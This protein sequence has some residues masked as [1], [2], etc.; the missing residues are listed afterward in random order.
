MADP[1]NVL[2]CAAAMAVVWTAIGW[3][4]ASRLETGPAAWCWAP[5]LGLALHSVVALPLLGW[6]GMDRPAVIAVTIALGAIA[7]VAGRFRHDRPLLAPL[8]IAKPLS[9]AM[10]V[11]VAAA[12]LLA[13]VPAAAVLPKTTDQGVTLAA[14]I[15]DHSKIAMIDEMIR[16][17]VPPHNPFIGPL[18][19]EAGSPDR[20]AYYYLWHFSAA[21]LA[22]VTGATGWEADAALTW[23][24]AF[25]SLLTMIGLAVRLGGKA[26]APAIVVV[27]AATASIRALFEWV[28]PDFTTPYLI[29][30]SGL[31]GWLF[32]MAWAPQHMA[33]ATCVVL[34]CLLLVRTAGR[35]DW[36][37]PPVLALVAAAGY[38][39]SIWVGGVTF[40][41][42]AVAIALYLLWSLDAPRRPGFLLRLLAAAILAL[43]F[44]LPFL[45]DQLAAGAARGGGA[46]VAI[47]PVAVLGPAFPASWRALLDL[48]AYWLVYL[49]V[50][51][52]A[53]YPAGLI[54]LFVLLKQRVGLPDRHLIVPLA[55]LA[56]ASLGVAWLM[57]S[58]VAYNNDLGWR[59][60][61]PAILLLIVFAA[62][63]IARWPA[64]PSR[65]TAGVAALGV[66]LTLPET[67]QYLR[68]DIF[69]SR[70]PSERLLAAT[71][72]LWQ[73]V[74]RHTAPNERVAN[75]PAF[76]GD[77][78][79]WAVNISWALMGDRRSCYAG[80]DLATAFAS[81]APAERAAI[82]QIFERV[83]S[84]APVGADVEQLANRFGCDTIVLT[85]QDGAW[86]RDPFLSGRVYRRVDSAEGWRIYRR[87]DP[88]MPLNQ[89][90]PRSSQ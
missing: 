27:L 22:V 62:T 25:A 30:A 73:A 9:I 47:A 57:R 46:P 65:V 76:L 66:L 69:A 8:S 37:A 56:A 32:Q 61:L 68:E 43:A 15:F 42:A 18:M 59:A 12:A 83:F 21:A 16:A 3:P 54:G 87:V 74:R 78:T 11:A 23:F 53:F 88:Q 35:G 31:A 1:G 40:A 28:A 48:P 26:A 7:F 17:G 70:L 13:L 4:I 39:T 45:R 82:D 89:L 51:F 2:L 36:F 49:P 81:V 38:E 72:S 50:E 20:L 19:G 44:C 75:N 90:K 79:P 29:G 60:I 6:T 85:P 86:Q 84:G 33:S 52:A 41:I 71:P 67:L 24:T 14:S 34:A 58:V 63:V 55:L 5:A 80:Y 64:K 10:I 77:M